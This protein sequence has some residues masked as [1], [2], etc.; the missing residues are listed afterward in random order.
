MGWNHQ[1]AYY[2]QGRGLARI[3]YG[4]VLTTEAAVVFHLRATSKCGT[5]SATRTA[6]GVAMAPKPSV[7]GGCNTMGTLKIWPLEKVIPLGNHHF[8]GGGFEYLLL[9]PLLWEDEPIVGLIRMFCFFVIEVWVILV[10]F[11]DSCLINMLMIVRGHEVM[12]F[13]HRSIS[14]KD[15]WFFWCF[16]HVLFALGY[17]SKAMGTCHGPWHDWPPGWCHFFGFQTSLAI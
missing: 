13:I 10:P 16:W 6:T 4:M 7:G 8:L 17:P 12:K 9:S 14:S 15:F 5:A 11:H 3:P 2:L 1:L